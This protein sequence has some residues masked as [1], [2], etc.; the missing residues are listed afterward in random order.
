[1]L[2]DSASYAYKLTPT[3]QAY[4]LTTYQQGENLVGYII[5]NLSGVTITNVTAS[6]YIYPLED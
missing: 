6:L 3:L 5:E 1:M 2:F 4:N